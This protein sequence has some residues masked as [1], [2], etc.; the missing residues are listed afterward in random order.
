MKP[1][2]LK[3]IFVTE[4][5]LPPLELL[6]KDL[7]TIWNNKRLTNNGPYCKRFEEQLQQISNCSHAL[8]V[9]NGSQA[10][11]LAVRALNLEGEVITSPYSFVASSSC[12]ALNKIKP[13]FVDIDPNTFNICPE[14]ILPKINSKTKAIL[15]IH[16]YGHKCDTEAIKEIATNNNLRVIYD[17]SHCMHP[18]NQEAESIFNEGDITTTSFHA[19]KVLNTLEGG[20]IFTN[21]N[22]LASKVSRLRNF[23]FTSE[24]EVDEISSN[25]KLNEVSASIGIL[26][27]ASLSKSIQKRQA[28]DNFY[29]NELSDIKWL[30][31]VAP[32]KQNPNYNYSYFPITINEYHP[33]GR[34]YVYDKLKEKNIFSRKYFFPL[35]T[36]FKAYRKFSPPNG[37]LKNSKQIASSILCLPIHEHLSDEDMQRIVSTLKSL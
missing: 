32:P 30:S 10:L 20:A 33:Y 8:A 14:K 26:Q 19:T 28:V 9:A 18:Y 22:E 34:D 3:P 16:V 37:E 1:E 36:D 23:G 15:G 24:V 12:L 27:L 29:R 17:G 4:P 21:D 2:S 25:S 35:I 7:E 6:Q 13:I 11:D 31:I 5:S